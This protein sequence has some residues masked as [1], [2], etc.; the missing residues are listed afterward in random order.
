M[1]TRPTLS[2]L[3]FGVGETCSHSGWPVGVAFLVLILALC[4]EEV[5]C[6]PGSLN[7][8]GGV[9]REKSLEELRREEQGMGCLLLPVRVEGY[10]DSCRIVGQ[11]MQ[12]SCHCQQMI[13]KQ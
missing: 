5:F 3:L 4:P 13:L 2:N 10:L 12:S 9:E 11:G 6:N 8:R 7:G 1:H